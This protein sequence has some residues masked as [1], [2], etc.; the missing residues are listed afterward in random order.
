MTVRHVALA[1][2]DQEGS[3]RFYE[4]YFGFG[5]RP[6]RRY[7]DG[8]L[9]IYDDAGFALALGPADGP[10]RMP[11]FFHIGFLARN[12][13]EVLALRGRLAA[14]GVEIV[15]EWPRSCNERSLGWTEQ[16]SLGC[17][18]RRKPKKEGTPWRPGTAARD[19]AA[20]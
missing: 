8:V 7:D 18:P 15:E 3:R 5:A 17:E 9:M 20:T 2:Q 11:P 14:D 16:S 10:V 12:R 4:R 6:S 13:T 19:G 1:V